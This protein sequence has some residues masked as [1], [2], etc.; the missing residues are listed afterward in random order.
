MRMDALIG[1]GSDY[2]V[3]EI[4]AEAAKSLLAVME[5]L[6]IATAREV[7]LPVLPNGCAMR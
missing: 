7:D 4:V 5:K 1:G 3:Y 6:K 2:P